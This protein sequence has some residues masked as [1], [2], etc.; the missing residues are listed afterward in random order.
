MHEAWMPSRRYWLVGLFFLVMVGFA[1]YRSSSFAVW[2]DS[3]RVFHPYGKDE[4]NVLRERLAREP[5]SEFGAECAKW[6]FLDVD[7]SGYRPLSNLWVYFVDLF[8]YRPSHVPMVVILAVGAVLGAFAVS[9]FYVARRFVRHDLTALAVVLLVLA[10]PPLIGSAWVCVAG[11]QVL[12]PLLY[13]LSLLCYWNLVEGKYRI[14]CAMILGLL[15]LLGPWVREFFGLNALLLLFLEF[16]RTRRPTCIAAAALLGFV[17]ALFPTALLHLLFLPQ[18]P[19]RPVYQLG[20]LSVQMNRGGIRWNA[21]WHFLPLFPP[22]LWLLAGVEAWRRIRTEHESVDQPRSNWLGRFETLVQRLA[23]PY[24]LW[25]LLALSVL[26]AV[27]QE[28]CFHDYLGL[29]LGLGLAALGMSRDVF[30]GCWFLSM[31][32]PIVR[33]FAEHVHFLYAMPPAAIIFAES[34]ESL[35]LRLRGRP[36]LLWGRYALAAVLVVI[37]LDQLLNV[38]GAYKANRAIY[39]GIDVVAAWFAR[40]VP[41]DAAVVSNAIH[42]EE[43]K[44]HSNNHFEMYWTVNTG[45]AEP[46]RALPEPAQLEHLLGKRDAHPVYFLDVDFD[47]TPDKVFYHQHKYVHQAEIA[48]RDLGVVHFT[49]VRYPFADPLRYLVPRMYQPFLGAPDLENDFARKR[50]VDHPFRHEIYAV[51]HVYEV[52][53]SRIT[54][55]LGGQVELVQEDVDGFNIVRV[56][57]GYHALPRGEGAFESEK[58]RYHGYSAQFSGLTPESVRDQIRAFRRGGEEEATEEKRD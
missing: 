45:I 23:L 20:S 47:Y 46:R 36:L 15:L 50:S 54:P 11:V 3:A 55:K 49:H 35:F 39:G 10:S 9:L 34:M 6:I 28:S 27:S 7:S 37:G 33:V 30:L 12:V 57:L 17:H 19:V 56:G 1:A 42:G 22:S 51:Y 53:G 44:W 14:L 26:H 2:D 43:I 13:C 24:W 8:L 40:N 48:R 16:R 4:R 32:L 58:F 18:L 29:T 38:Y 41:A 31:Y 25:T 21:P 5:F 52:T